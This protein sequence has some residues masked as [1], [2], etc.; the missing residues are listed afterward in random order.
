MIRTF[1][2]SFLV[3]MILSSYALQFPQ[4]LIITPVCAVICRF[5]STFRYT[6]ALPRKVV[7]SLDFAPVSKCGLAV[8]WAPSDYTYP[9]VNSSGPRTLNAVFWRLSSE[10]YMQLSGLVLFLTY[11]PCHLKHDLA[12]KK[13]LMSF[14]SCF[15]L[16]L[17]RFSSRLLVCS[18]RA[19]NLTSVHQQ[20]L[21]SPLFLC[22]LQ[23]YQASIIVSQLVFLLLLCPLS[24]L[25]VLPL[26]C[27]IILLYLTINDAIYLWVCCLLYSPSGM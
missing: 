7:E 13:S 2:F 25:D 21:F 12:V 18:G 23:L 1:E 10:L 8:V 3:L 26:P 9:Q 20:V 5:S 4:H 24:S 19:L 11:L 27:F 15:S 14:V 16:R 6:S 22:P 17:L